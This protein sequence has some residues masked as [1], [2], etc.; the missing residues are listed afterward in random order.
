MPSVTEIQNQVVETVKKG[1]TLA[2]ET[3]K[4]WTETVSGFVPESLPFADQIPNFI[5]QA[6][7]A[8]ATAFTIAE[9]TVARQ[10]E[11]VL[12]ILDTVEDRL[13]KAQAPAKNGAKAPAAKTEAAKPEAE[14]EASA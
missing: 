10:R 14:A 7:S 9:Q 8:V 4:G 6:K 2:S 11:L 5:P 12:G 13:A 3:V 1:Q